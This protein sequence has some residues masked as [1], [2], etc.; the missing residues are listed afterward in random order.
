MMPN[1]PLHPFRLSVSDLIGRPGAQRPVR[2][3]G[4]LEIGL[5]RIDDC[6]PVSARLIIEEISGGVLVRGEAA[7]S[8]RLQCNRCLASTPFEAA[9]PVLLVC[10]E[11]PPG[12]A[13]GVDEEALPIT[14]D[15]EIDLAE[16]LR[17]ELSLSVPLAPLCS[18]ACRGL[19]PA[20]GSDLNEEPCGGH[21]E[22]AGSPFS[23]LEGLLDPPQTGG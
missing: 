14:P 17:G 3:S 15:G 11:T 22:P 1:E 12:E 10:G 2:L 4:S 18:R 5:D 8:M 20:C 9:A 23:A 21:S 16:A 7:A 13:G 19:C 6:G